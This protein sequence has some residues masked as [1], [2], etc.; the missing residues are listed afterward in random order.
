MVIA[1]L[2]RYDQDRDCDCGQTCMSGMCEYSDGEY[3]KFEE[4][5]E[6]SSNSL[7][8][9]KAKIAALADIIADDIAGHADTDRRYVIKRLRQLSAV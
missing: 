4:A 2:T 6:A 9:L 7:Q 8:Q 5:M 3:V 1:N